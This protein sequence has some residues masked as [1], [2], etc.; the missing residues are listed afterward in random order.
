M[1][2]TPDYSAYS[3]QELCDARAT[4]DEALYP[5]R[6][7]QLDEL[8]ASHAE[9]ISEESS[10]VLDKESTFLRKSPVNFHGSAKEFFSI[11]IVNLLLSIV[12]LGIYSAW[13]K[14]RTNRYL[15]GNLEIDG[16]RFSYL[17]EPLQILKGRIISAI[18]LVG[19]I[20]AIS[21]SP[22]V[23]VV[24][25]LA[26]A[27]LS[28]WLIC[29]GMQFGMKMTSYRNVRFGFTGRYGEAFL[30]F[31]LFPFL[32]VFTLYLAMPWA[33]KKMDEF[34]LNNTTYGD[35]AFSTELSGGT[36]FVAGLAAGVVSIITFIVGISLI[37]A[38]AVFAGAKESAEQAGSISVMLGVFILYFLV[39]TLASAIYS[40]MI[41]NHMYAQTRLAN[42][43]TFESN[44][45]VGGFLVLKITNMLAL[46]FSLGLALPWVKT[47]TLSYLAGHTQVNVLDG[48]DSVV[49][50][51]EQIGTATAEEVASAFDLDV[52]LG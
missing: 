52:S 31:L 13:A 43:A 32:T 3:Y 45:T 29:K 24:M 44:V 21:T 18:L 26:V 22:I 48:I 30:V 47:R 41:R 27:I 20:L 49:A 34:I 39:F 46:V 37:G 17:A 9:H 51:N 5:E 23:A 14:V 35:K 42:V 38:T 7:K 19:Y 2:T 25:A 10:Q 1:D 4:L 12:T 15:Y 11:W 50:S 33:L 28:P 36:Y 40:G 6:A 8:I 16:H